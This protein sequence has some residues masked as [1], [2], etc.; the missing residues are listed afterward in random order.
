MFKT[1]ALEDAAGYCHS[2][3]HQGSSSEFQEELWTPTDPN[4]ELH[5]QAS[6]FGKFY[7]T[8]KTVIWPW[9]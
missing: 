8:L 3:E 6:D 4:T 9:N 5:A 2:Q 7:F 1:Q